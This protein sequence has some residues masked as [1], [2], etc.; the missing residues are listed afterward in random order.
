MLIEYTSSL[1]MFCKPV[2]TRSTN[3]RVGAT[4]VC[5]KCKKAPR[6]F[7]RRRVDIPT[8]ATRRRSYSFS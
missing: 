5:R 1:Y 4:Q 7:I 6:N 8:W 3:F 2:F